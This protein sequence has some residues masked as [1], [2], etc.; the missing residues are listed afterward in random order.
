MPSRLWPLLA[1][2]ALTDCTCRGAP[3]RECEAVANVQSDQQGAC[4]ASSQC[5]EHYACS[6]APDD[7]SLMCCLLVDRAC[8]T[9]ADCCPGQRCPSD[10]N[11]CFD[12]YLACD[13]D[14]DCGDLGDRFCETWTD[15]YGTSQRCRLRACGEGGSC[16]D[17]QSCFSGE[18]IADVPCGGGC[19]AGKAC[20]PS[21]NRCQAYDCAQSCEVG[22]I[23]TFKDTR[24]IWDKCALPAVGCACAELPP[25][26]SND[27]GR[28]SAIASSGTL[29]WVSTYDGQYGDLVV[30]AYDS[31]GS[32]VQERYLDGVPAT[33]LV[34]YGP[35][36]PRGGITDP[37]PDVGRYSDVATGV[38][39]EVYVSYF[40]VTNGDLKLAARSPDGAWATTTVDGAN[41]DLGLYT[42]VAVDS[43]GRPGIAYFQRGGSVSFDP[44]TCPGGAPSGPRELITAL[45]FA[46]AGGSSLP[47][48]FTITTVSCAARP[49]P[50]CFNCADVCADPGT[51]PDCFASATGCSACDTFAEVCV[52]A[53]GA[54]TCAARFTPV[55]VAEAPDGV[56]LFASLAF[57]GA[58]AL[59]VYQRRQDRKGQLYGVKVSASGA[60]G[61]PVLLDG[62][63]DTGYF[64]DIEL[65]PQAVGKVAIA[66]HDFATRELKFLSQTAFIASQPPTVI[67]TGVGEVGSGEF[68]WVGA[69]AT[70]VPSPQG[71]L[72]VLYQDATRGDLKAAARDGA[73]WTV[74]PPLRTEGAVGFF[75]DGAFVGSTFLASHAQ[76]HARTVN[77]EP[78]VD[79]RL[80]VGR[81]SP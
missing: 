12:R 50:T 27:L 18:C 64:P 13:T 3:G 23:S 53:N 44:A 43:S 71:R 25:L 60:P 45:K 62:S 20:I 24:D 48:T 8:Q 46:R 11:K 72:Y 55:T 22:F 6:A 31:G 15:A 39:G 29:A 73:T 69:D 37:G 68:D 10:R 49:A 14:A 74:L 26:R 57:D 58:E 4:T 81:I 16:A 47:T 41:A 56:G 36:G 59:I 32:L 5:N 79:N 75:A 9:E 51:G 54:P 1:L 17:G 19:P 78:R 28:F 77:G 40:D 33:G 21:T 30:R 34:R 35:S 67:D 7:A 38:N 52:L 61:T 65:D 76:L 2:I 63:G 42:S 70:L 80:L 66:Y